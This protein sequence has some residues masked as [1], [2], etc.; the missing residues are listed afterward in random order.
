M[1]ARD[2]DASAIAER[3]PTLGDLVAVARVW[4]RVFARSPADTEPI[5]FEDGCLV[6]LCSAADPLEMI[7]EHAEQ[8]PGLLNRLLDGAPLVTGVEVLEATRAEVYLARDLLAMKLLL[9]DSG[10]TVPTPPRTNR[11][12]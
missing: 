3:F 2:L 12:R 9:V 6:V 4:P 8:I 5:A 11:S 1:T 7:R 10:V